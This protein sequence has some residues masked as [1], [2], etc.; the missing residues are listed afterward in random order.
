MC[1]LICNYSTT[2]TCEAG[3]DGP[4]ACATSEDARAS[5]DSMLGLLQQFVD[6]GRG[7]MH[8]ASSQKKKKKKKKAKGPE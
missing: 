1:S 6:C 5:D 7:R 4:T 2:A 3:D 8:E